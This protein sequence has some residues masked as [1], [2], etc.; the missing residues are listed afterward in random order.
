MSFVPDLEP[1][2]TVLLH[3]SYR[4]SQKSEPFAIAVSDRAVFIPAKKAF[5]VRDPYYF[6]RVPHAR[7]HSV[8]VRKLNPVAL[9]SLAVVMV[10]TGALTTT[11]M[12][13]PIFS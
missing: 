7:V 3:E 13:M 2:E 8:T 12:M 6:K 4:P 1:G 5:A 10:V 11:W 9:W